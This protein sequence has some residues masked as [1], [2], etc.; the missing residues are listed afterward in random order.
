[1]T[2]GGAG[3]AR[4][5]VRVDCDARA[6]FGPSIAAP[7]PERMENEPKLSHALRMV[8]WR[9]WTAKAWAEI[10]AAT[11]GF[12]MVLTGDTWCPRN[13]EI[14]VSSYDHVDLD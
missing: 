12:P 2:R 13:P 6:A 7:A 5:A 8:T 3:G 11:G 4:R 10:K 9:Q 14:D 1:M